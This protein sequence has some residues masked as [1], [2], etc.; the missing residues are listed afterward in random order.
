[1]N[2]RGFLAALGAVAAAPVAVARRAARPTAKYVVT[3][4]DR[5]GRRLKKVE[6]LTMQGAVNQL[7]A[8]QGAAPF[9]YLTVIDDD[10]FNRLAEAAFDANHPDLGYWRSGAMAG[11]F[12]RAYNGERRA[13]CRASR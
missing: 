4:I 8:E 12:R 11:N 2:R 6:H 7:R 13:R 9:S 5:R 3:L 1:M 10:E